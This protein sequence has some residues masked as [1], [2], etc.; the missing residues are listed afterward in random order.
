MARLQV[1]PPSSA[2]CGVVSG[3]WPRLV[4]EL[5]PSRTPLGRVYH[6][7]ELHELFADFGRGFML[8]PVAHI[9][10]FEVPH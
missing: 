9:V 2:S 5:L 7:Q 4:W 3:K 6:A 10:E 8:Y 1:R